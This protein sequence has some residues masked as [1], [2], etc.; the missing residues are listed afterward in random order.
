MREKRECT[1]R[2]GGGEGQTRE[3]HGRADG[4]VGTGLQSTDL[5]EMLGA[6]L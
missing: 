5:W 4:A 1:M 3:D 6:D 2:F